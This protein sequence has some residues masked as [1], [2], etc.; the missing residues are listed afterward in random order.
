MPFSD[1]A[2]CF[3]L[4]AYIILRNGADLISILKVRTPNDSGI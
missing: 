1:C 4:N 3:C 2:I